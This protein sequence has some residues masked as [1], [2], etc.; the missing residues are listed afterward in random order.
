MYRLLML[1]LVC[2]ALFP[3]RAFAEN[4]ATPFQNWWCQQINEGIFA[5]TRFAL[6]T[7]P[8]QAISIII[9]ANG[10]QAILKQR[11]TAYLQ[12]YNV[13]KDTLVYALPGTPEDESTRFTVESADSAT[14]MRA[15]GAWMGYGR[16]PQLDTAINSAMEHLPPQAFIRFSGTLLAEDGSPL[17]LHNPDTRTV[18]PL[19]KALVSLLGSEPCVV[20]AYKEAWKEDGAKA[21]IAIMV[22]TPGGAIYGLK[23]SADNSELY[24]IAASSWDKKPVWTVPLAKGQ[25]GL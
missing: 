2:T 20:Q 19:S 25:K 17:F 13:E 18:T 7:E 12:Q 3:T 6:A 14:K 21:G 16:L 5:C 23:L 4:E 24:V 10:E 22:A 1:F 15:G 9:R 11:E 8:A